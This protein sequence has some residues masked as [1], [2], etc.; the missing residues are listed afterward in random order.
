MR[1]LKNPNLADFI[2]G[3]I[4]GAVIYALSY[5]I[6]WIKAWPKALARAW[7]RVRALLAKEPRP[8]TS[9]R[10]TGDF[11]RWTLCGGIYG[12]LVMVITF[13]F[14]NNDA[15]IERLIFFD[16]DFFNRTRVPTDI[17]GPRHLLALI[18]LGVPLLLVA[19]L[20]AEMI[21]VGV[22]SGEPDSEEDRE[23]LGRAAGLFFL[24]GLGWLVVMHLAYIGSDITYNLIEFFIKHP[25]E[26]M[27]VLVVLYV[28]GAV[29][30]GIGRSSRT[31]ARGE[32]ASAK[33]KS[34]SATLSLIAAILG[35]TLV[36]GMSAL[37]DYVVLGH[38]IAE[39]VKANPGA[40]LLQ[41]DRFK[42]FVALVTVVMVTL[43]S[44][45]SININR[46]SMHSLY[47][48]RLIRTFL[49]ASNPKRRPN[50]FTNFAPN[51]NPRMHTLWPSRHAWSGEAIGHD[52]PANKRSWRPFH[53]VNIAL[54]V[55][56][57]RE[58]LEWQ[59]RKAASFTV[60]PLHCGSSITGFR[61]SELYGGGIS[62][63][64]AMAV[65]GAAASPNQGYNSSPSVAFLMALFNVRL[66]WWL[67]NPGPRGALT[68]TYDG[69]KNA[70][71]PFL[72]EMLGMTSDDNK[73]V[74]LSD[75]GHFE[76]LGLYEMVRRRCRF[77]VL[78]DAGCDPKFT[79]ED[80]GN[81]VRKIEID[82]GVPI[83]F[84]DL[85]KLKARQNQEALE[86]LLGG[87]ALPR[88][89]RAD[90][91]P[92]PYHA[93]GVIDYPSADGHGSPGGI[94][95]TKGVILYIKPGFHGNESSA[96][97]RSYASMN[98][99]FPHDDTANQFFGE[100]QMESY[101]ALGFEIT[102]TLL[103]KALTDL[104]PGTEPTL[105]AMINALAG[106]DAVPE[107]VQATS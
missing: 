82:L 60:S 54:N 58:H 5:A 13:V 98:P 92:P 55:T 9:E 2:G 88:A 35:V 12:A 1:A 34:A 40:G 71:V 44:S 89:D 94:P 61:K 74:Y 48:N 24:A 81:A 52:Q 97:I 42:L 49:G 33:A 23:W 68:H 102:D 22:T 73:Y 31:P 8:T 29:A 3:A 51:D 4:V 90:Q 19:Q 64:T 107:P 6:S 99:N 96:G 57:S 72:A 77:I 86:E 46:F 66:G 100:S 15:P 45:R 11:W 69:P 84:R 67:G 16:F 26:F 21:F 47:R 62:L 10:G 25:L 85:D 93:V 41:S 95:V 91:K 43:V 105:R 50:P 14:L 79:F 7:T 39:D 78:V 37:V 104:K 32:Q 103:R 56:S 20:I 27:G 76:N 53:I 101:R 70:I 75:G 28:V 87:L 38:A 80:L 106:R 17:A 18:Y 63:G 36:I 65:S 59:E 83:T 30:A